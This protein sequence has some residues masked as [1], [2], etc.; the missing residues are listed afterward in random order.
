M[1]A[2]QRRLSH[3]HTNDLA[4]EQAEQYCLTRAPTFW[5]REQLAQ[6]AE[7]RHLNQSHAT[8]LV[9]QHAEQHHLTRPPP[10]RATVLARLGQSRWHRWYTGR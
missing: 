2:E 8:H 7:Q 5:R 3:L 9:A 1:Q 4:A 6:Q 10:A